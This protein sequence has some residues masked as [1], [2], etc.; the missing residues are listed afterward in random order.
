STIFK[1]VSC[2]KLR[3]VCF[4]SKP[5]PPARTPTC[6]AHSAQDAGGGRDADGDRSRRDDGRS[7]R[8]SVMRRDVCAIQ[9]SIAHEL[10]ASSFGMR[11]DI[12]E[13]WHAGDPNRNRSIS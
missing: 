5:L 10:A 11:Q 8:S 12:Y 3:Y 1:V 4:Q 7:V 9:M 2:A 13:Y 6:Y